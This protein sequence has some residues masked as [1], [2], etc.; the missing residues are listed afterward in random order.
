[1]H[2]LVICFG[3]FRLLSCLGYTAYLEI[4]VFFYSEKNH[5]IEEQQR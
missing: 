3:F 5:C 2:E 1:M 4:V